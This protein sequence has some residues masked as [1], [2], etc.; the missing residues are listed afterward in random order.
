[1]VEFNLPLSIACLLVIIHLGGTWNP[2]AGITDFSS[3]GNCE[4]FVSPIKELTLMSLLTNN[5]T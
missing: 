2:K 3:D 4:N 1:M 5:I